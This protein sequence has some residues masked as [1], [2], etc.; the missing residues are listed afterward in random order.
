MQVQR[1]RALTDARGRIVVRA[2]A[3]A[4]IAAEVAL[5]LPFADAERHA[6]K[7]GA[8][9]ERNQPLALAGLGA[10]GEALRVAQLAQLNRIGGLH[11]GRG[12]LLDEHRL[13]APAG[14]NSLTRLDLGNIDLD[15]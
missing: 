11:F 10:V 9:A 3:R 13:L 2:V 5:G 14:L 15:R 4:E 1:R 7:M 12:Q 8:D 6:A